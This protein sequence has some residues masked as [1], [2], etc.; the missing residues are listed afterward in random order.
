MVPTVNERTE[1][2]RDDEP[3]ELIDCIRVVEGP[4]P[5]YVPEIRLRERDLEISRLL[6]EVAALGERV[7]VLTEA[8]ID[9]RGQFFADPPYV[10]WMARMLAGVDAAL[11]DPDV[12]R[13]GVST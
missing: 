7:R 13:E 4:I 5:R 12:S 3:E 8:L 11:A 2:I 1:Q 6:A 9:V 10:G